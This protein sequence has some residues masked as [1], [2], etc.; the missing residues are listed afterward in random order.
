MNEIAW[1]SMQCEGQDGSIQSLELPRVEWMQVKQWSQSKEE[2]LSYRME[3]TEY[4]QKNG[5]S[6]EFSAVSN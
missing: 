6:T 5:W 1:A 2:T 4:F 3:K